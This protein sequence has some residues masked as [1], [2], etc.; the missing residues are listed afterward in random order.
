MMNLQSRPSTQKPTTTPRVHPLLLLGLSAALAYTGVLWLNVFHDLTGG[1]ED[2]ELPLAVHALRDGT[3]ALPVVIL[4]VTGA[5][6]LA[7]WLLQATPSATARLRF[8]VTSVLAAG[9]A[10]MA[11][12]AGNPVHERLFG[13]HEHAG[14]P[15]LLHVARDSV[16]ALAVCL[17][18]AAA[19]VILHGKTHRLSSLTIAMEATAAPAPLPPPSRRPAR[20]FLAGATATS[21][22]AFSGLQV[23]T[24]AA[25]ASAAGT[26]VCATA[27]RT[28]NYD[29]KAFELD[30]PLNGWGDHIPNGLMY[31]L[32][33]PD[34]QP[35]IAQILAEPGR[36]TPLVLRAAV[37]DCICITFNASP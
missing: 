19:V 12:A 24:V 1:H 20:A 28:I 23:A 3:L 17:P 36:S 15:L 11:L 5:L 16:I 35:T 25:P 26:G 31:A 7:R 29:V 18:M 9:A 22:I 13:A 34:A 10:A 33:N 27:V 21:V 37:G 4:A 8:A 2:H 30:L 6:F 14:L 32:A